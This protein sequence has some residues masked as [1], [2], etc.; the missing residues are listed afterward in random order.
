MAKR[1]PLYLELPDYTQ[2]EEDTLATEMAGF[3]PNLVP[4][5]F[6]T[7]LQESRR[8][9]GLAFETIIPIAP[10]II[11][12]A[13]TTVQGT[14]PATGTPSG[15]FLKDDLT[16]AAGAGGAAWGA[17]TGT[18]AD[19]TDLQTAL[20]AKADDL[21]AD[22]NYVT[23]AEKTKLSNLSGTNTGDQTLPTDATI[24]TTDVTTNDASL[25]KHGWLKK[26]P[27]G[28][29]TFLRADGAFA[30]PTASVAITEAEIDVGATPV[31]EASISVTDAGVS[32][33]SKII[34]GIAYKAP[35]GKELDELEEPLEV[36]FEPLT[37]T[38][39]VH[40]KGLEGYI[41]DTFVVW[42]LFA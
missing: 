40:I 37:G 39:N 15:K 12:L 9:D 24:V 26:L 34:G 5:I 35:T 18:L 8:W 28:T 22:D 3:P 38:F 21:G 32:T 4:I 23:D 7:T 41:S 27:G 13:T 19:Q 25:S 6:N 30:A 29:T 14:V 1:I 11:P 33:S 10:E 36:K 20:D 16:W 2:A 31:A 42:Y 17:I